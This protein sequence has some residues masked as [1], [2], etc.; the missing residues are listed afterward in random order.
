MP[1]G[2]LRTPVLIAAVPTLEDQRAIVLMVDDNFLGE[3]HEAVTRIGTEPLEDGTEITDHAAAA[4][5]RLTLR[6]VLSDFGGIQSAIEA[7]QQIKAIHRAG[8]AVR[9]ISEIETYPE[10]LFGRVAAERRGRAFNLT[11]EMR[12]LL[13]VPAPIIL[14]PPLPSGA[15]FRFRSAD[16]QRA[17][18][19]AALATNPDA[20]PTVV[21]RLWARYRNRLR[22]R[23]IRDDPDFN[24]LE[25]IQN[26]VAFERASVGIRYFLDQQA[27][28]SRARLGPRS[29]RLAHG[30][31]ATVGNNVSYGR[32]RVIPRGRV[33]LAPTAAAGLADRPE[34]PERAR[35]PR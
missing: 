24:S 7:W 11:L 33:S 21:S 17:D 31:V 8:E 35:R 18:F 13:R 5:D 19:E 3:R 2:V 28:H 6:A 10:M 20:D 1:D 16:D 14:P 25:T 22:N 23:A 29:V 4:P 26:R 27:D 15:G 9:V 32:N 34:T 12:A 30:G